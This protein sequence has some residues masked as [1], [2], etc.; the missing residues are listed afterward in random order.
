M[1]FVKIDMTDRNKKVK[2][3]KFSDQAIGALMMA[4]QRCLLEQSDITDIIRSFNLKFNEDGELF[5]INPPLV[6][7]ND[8]EE[9]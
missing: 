5:V 7:L 4:L 9:E 1:K 2:D 8:S 3:F 6:K